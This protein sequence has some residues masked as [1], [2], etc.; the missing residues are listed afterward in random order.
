MTAMMATTPIT[1]PIIAPTGKLD[2]VEGVMDGDVVSEVGEVVV[3]GIDVVDVTV[4][5]ELEVNLLDVVVVDIEAGDVVVVLDEIETTLEKLPL[6][7]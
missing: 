4:V 2:G 7:A 1:I 6:L 3:R 5:S